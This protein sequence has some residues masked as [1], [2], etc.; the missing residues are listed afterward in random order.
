MRSAHAFA[1]LDEPVR[2]CELGAD[3]GEPAVT[4]RTEWLDVDQLP[5]LYEY[6][7]GQC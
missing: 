5:G 6:R 7:R 4:V 3:A 1:F 2:N